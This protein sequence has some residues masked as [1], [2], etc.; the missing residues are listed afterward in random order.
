MTTNLTALIMKPYVI[1]LVSNPVWGG[2]EQYVL[3][4][5]RKLIDAGYGVEVVARPAADV[6]SKFRQARVPVRKLPLRGNIDFISSIALGRIIRKA[7][8]G[9]VVI[10]AHNFKTAANAVTA[11]RLSGRADV[12]VVV[13]RHLVKPGK[14]DSYH[15]DL[16]REIDRIVFVSAL[17]RDRFL[18]SSPVVDRSKICVV[19]N[20]VEAIAAEPLLHHGADAVPV[21]MWHGRI[22]PEKGLDTLIEALGSLTSRQWQL[23]LAGTGQ[24]RDVS[25]L[26]RRIRELDMADRVEWLGYVND[27]PAEIREQ[28][29]FV[30]VLPSRV[31]E[32]FGLALLD[33]MSCGV[34]VITTDNGAQS[35]IITDGV[36]G[37]LFAPD[38]SEA[39]ARALGRMIDD[40][41]GRDRMA[42]EALHTA[43][44]RFSYNRFFEAIT[45]A[46]TFE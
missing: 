39:M 15:T 17:S 34:P 46:Y 22:N 41:A 1:Q 45:R 8:A 7:P 38:D 4:L 5:S 10:H 29:V 16:Y 36:D 23:K 25:P 14:T 6:V 40:R 44:T 42:R 32:A 3:D 31:P 12:R 21:I 9:P 11:R 28:N 26:V 18:S 24:A 19:H 35:E 2:G 27:V 43:A 30:G 37:M 13:T 20:G 33:Y